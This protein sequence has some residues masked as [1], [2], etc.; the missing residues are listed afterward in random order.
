MMPPSVQ[1]PWRTREWASRA[2]SRISGR[3]AEPG[4][5]RLRDTRH[6]WTYIFGVVR[7]GRAVAAGLVLPFANTDA[8]NLHLAEIA[9][10]IA[11]GAHAIL[12]LDG[13]G[14]HKSNDVA[15]PEN[16][17]L[18]I[19]PPC[20]RELNPVENVWQYPCSNK[21]AVSDFEG[22]DH[23]VDACR[24]AWNFLEKDPRA[25]TMITSRNWAKVSRQGRW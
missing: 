7:P 16:I 3:A 20:A 24:S 10:T 14:W 1:G 22:Y 13:A 17:S 15:V 21:F 4:P 8:M 23:I 9:G 2:R 6:K 25:V 11:H 5:A 19:L 18:L 12:V